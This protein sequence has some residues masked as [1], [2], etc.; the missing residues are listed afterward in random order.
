MAFMEEEI[1]SKKPRDIKKIIGNLLILGALILLVFIYYPLLTF[2][3]PISNQVLADSSYYLSIPKIKAS[4]PII[5]QVDPWNESEYKE[6]LKQGVA[7]AKGFSTVGEKGPVFLFAHSSDYPWNMT[8]TN[9]AFFRLGELENGDQIK[10]YK[11]G[12]E[13]IYQVFA[14][15]E[16]WPNQVENLKLDQD[17]LILQTCTPIGTSLKRLLIYAKPS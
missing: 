5:S 9:T 6:R 13:Y 17:I 16:V 1:P 11:K 8:R 7:E 12:R 15:K 2:Y 14:K 10:I 3:L 4:A